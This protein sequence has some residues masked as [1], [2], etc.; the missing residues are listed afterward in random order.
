MAKKE[1]PSI[2]NILEIGCGTGQNLVWLHTAF[3][4]ALITGLELS[5]DM[6]NKARS[7]KILQNSKINF[8][9][10][11]LLSTPNPPGNQD[12]IVLSYILT[13]VPKIRK[14]ILQRASDLLSAEGAL[15][16]IDFHDSN[17]RYFRSWMRKNHVEMGRDLL[18][19]FENS[20]LQTQFSKVQKAYFGLWSYFIYIGKRS[21]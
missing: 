11:D 20:D 1:F 21:L 12:L 6:L 8:I 18:D 7:K 15:L 13:M 19:E 2:R 3:P 14:E 4:N 5:P 10:G 16:V 9:D 17:H